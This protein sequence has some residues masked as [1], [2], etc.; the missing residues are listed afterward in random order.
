MPYTRDGIRPDIIISTHTLPSTYMAEY[1]YA[2]SLVMWYLCRSSIR[3]SAASV[4]LWSGGRPIMYHHHCVWFMARQNRPP[5]L[6]TK[7]GS[8]AILSIQRSGQKEWWWLRPWRCVTEQC[9]EK[10]PTFSLSLIQRRHFL[11]APTTPT[12]YL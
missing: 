11:L 10:T 2:A 8:L 6:W 9:E 4:D 7:F 5:A 3:K 1:Q 12:Y